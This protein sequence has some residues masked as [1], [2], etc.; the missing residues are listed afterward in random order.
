MANDIKS[1]D[2]VA[3]M[4]RIDETTDKLSSTTSSIDKLVKE[5]NFK[6]EV[7]ELQKQNSQILKHLSSLEK[8]IDEG[9][10]V[11]KKKWFA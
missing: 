11:K 2:A 10:N 3:I 8:Q 7:E 4:K 6:E 9:V 1:I 5:M